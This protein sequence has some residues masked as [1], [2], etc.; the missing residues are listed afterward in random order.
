MGKESGWRIK[1]ELEEW[2]LVIRWEGKSLKVFGRTG[3]ERKRAIVQG[4]LGLLLMI[5]V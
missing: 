5:S 3:K 4:A 1:Q 2:N